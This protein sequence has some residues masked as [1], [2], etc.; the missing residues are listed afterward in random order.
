MGPKTARISLF[1][2]T[3]KERKG[4][5]GQKFDVSDRAKLRGG[6]GESQIHPS[7]HPITSAAARPIRALSAARKRE[8]IVADQ[9]PIVSG[10]AGRY[11]SALFELADES[12]ALDKVGADLAQFGTILSGSAD[13][14]ALVRNPVFTADE[15]VRALSAILDKAGIG[16][17][18]ANFLKLV[19]S[20][21]RLF[22]VDGMVRGFQQLVDARNG[23]VSAEVTVPAAL[24]EKNKAAV[25]EALKGV[26]GG[27]SI[28]LFEKID[29]SIVGGLIVKIGSK[30]VDASLKTKLN[31][32]KL[33][34]K[35]VG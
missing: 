18:A 9:G 7:D 2:K 35:E 34:M 26:T 31:S 19:A 20:K 1:A 17:I 23:V 32:I 15:Q 3:R 10:I 30:M 24:S 14:Q 25:L 4:L 8:I 11:A 33:A 21:R 12:K 29:P 27:K 5:H 16:G 22:A 6:A 13:L 28:S